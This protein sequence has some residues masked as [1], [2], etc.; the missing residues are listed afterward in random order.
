[1]KKIS[2][3]IDELLVAYLEGALAGEKLEKIKNG[4]ATSEELRNRLEVLKL[5]QQ[6]LER[7]TLL[8]PSDNFT[9]RVMGNLDKVPSA[10]MLTPKN[11]LILLAGIL[12]AMGIGASLVDT[13][14][15]NE[16][17]GMLSLNPIK[18]PTGVS[19]PTLPAIPLSGKL[20]VNSIIALNLG[21]AFLLLDRTILKP[22]FNRRSRMQF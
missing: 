22:F 19:T 9:Q 5:I 12:V 7:N 20:I 15:F 10:S 13:G 3:E 17:N 14:L 6:S 11:G 1:M 2:Q 8:H 21:L 18:L 16:L 4:L